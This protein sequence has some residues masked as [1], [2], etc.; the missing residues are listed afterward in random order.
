MSLNVKFGKTA[1]SPIAIL[2]TTH[3]LDVAEE[4]SDRVAIINQGTINYDSNNDGN[5]DATGVTDERGSV[6]RFGETVLVVPVTV[7]ALALLKQALS[8]ATG[9]N[10]KFDFVARG[11]LSGGGVIATRFETRGEFDL[12]AGLAGAAGSLPRY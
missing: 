12:P 11:K 10:T 7:S 6:P 9:G 2:L 5:N 3:Q 1:V 8:F 4:L